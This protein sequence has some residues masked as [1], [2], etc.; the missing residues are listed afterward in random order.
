ML[1]AGSPTHPE[2]RFMNPIFS[3][4]HHICIVVADIGAAQRYYESIGI[5]PWHDYPPLSDFTDLT[6]PNPD[7]FRQ[8]IFK[9]ADLPN[10]Q[11]Q[12]CEP[13]S[14]DTPQRRFLERK[15]PGV[16]HVGF[17]VDD[18]G[19]AEQQAT[20]VGLAPLMRG[21]R[22]DGSGFTYFDTEDEAGVILEVRKAKGS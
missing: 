14:A 1:A 5:G 12:L 16:F 22:P 8:L 10:L 15:G 3:Q 17:S 4:A 13:G 9:Y 6:M 2:H 7:G 20:A 19:T 11:L 18:L 21:R